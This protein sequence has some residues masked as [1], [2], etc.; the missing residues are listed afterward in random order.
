MNVAAGHSGVAEHTSR[1]KRFCVWAC[2]R[3]H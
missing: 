1:A 3:P 2:A